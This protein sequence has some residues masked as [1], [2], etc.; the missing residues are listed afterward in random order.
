[1]KLVMFDMDGT[2]TDGFA[3]EEN[4]YVRAIEQ[5]LQ[6]NGVVTEWD[7]YTHTSASFCL[8]EIVQRARGIPPT[9]EESRAVQE[10]MVGLMR[11]IEQLHG[12]RT[13]EIPG[14]S[15]VI[16][17]LL[18]L[19]YAVAIASGDWE[20]TAR[21]K[22]TT[23]G[24]P[25]QNLPAAFCDCADPRT[26]IMLTALA[27]AQQHYHRS[28]FDRIVYVG[29]A[30]WDVRA[31]R[32]LGWPLIG[33]GDGA[34]ASRLQTLG[35]THVIPHYEPLAKFLAVLEQASVPAPAAAA[36]R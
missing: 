4:C 7:T 2:L 18:K 3:L 16:R 19:G 30:A 34:L 14:A 21:H 17:E 31:C 23:A 10:R 6:L 27:R 25:F 35:V 29:D 22:L 9:P 26:E 8:R 36:Q 24:I 33:V 15:K 1:M 28:K 13:L 20:S 11:E 12:R 32:E 5:A